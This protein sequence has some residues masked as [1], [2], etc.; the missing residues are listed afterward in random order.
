MGQIRAFAPFERG[1]SLLGYLHRRLVGGNSHR[2][3]SA[4]VLALHHLKHFDRTVVVVGA[5][6][7]AAGLLWIAKFLIFDR[8]FR[9]TLGEFEVDLVGR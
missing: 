9:H 4:P 7:V 3:L 5:T 6:S 8:L 2:G 1:S